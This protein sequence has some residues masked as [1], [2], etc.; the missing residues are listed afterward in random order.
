[1]NKRQR[2]KLRKR[3]KIYPNIITE[4]IDRTTIAI[5]DILPSRDEI[6]QKQQLIFKDCADIFKSTPDV[7]LIDKDELYDMFFQEDNKNE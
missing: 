4:F 7:V 5:D 3:K 1:M 2:K 6:L